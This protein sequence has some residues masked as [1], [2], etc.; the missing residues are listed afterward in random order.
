MY[1]PFA[2]SFFWVGGDR[3]SPVSGTYTPNYYPQTPRAS[4]LVGSQEAEPQ[5]VFWRTEEVPAKAAASYAA[6]K[7]AVKA[8]WK[9]QK[10]REM[11][12]NR[13]EA[14]AN[15]I[16]TGGPTSEALLPGFLEDELAKLRSEFADPKARERTAGFLVDGVAPLT[17]VANPTGRSGLHPPLFPAPGGQLQPFNFIPTVNVKYPSLAMV[18]ELVESRTKPPKSVL[19]LPDEPKDVYY[20]VTLLKRDV[21]KDTDFAREVY[22]AGPRNPTRDIVLDQFRGDQRRKAIESVMGLLKKEFRYEETEEQKKKLDE[23]EKRGGDA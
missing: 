11:A 16:R 1:I 15:T 8:A 21:K 3:R 12:K 9:R 20:V 6:A 18:R 17:M 7:D 19:V 4:D 14:M 2:N 5:Y 13:A 10:A 22:D 23:N